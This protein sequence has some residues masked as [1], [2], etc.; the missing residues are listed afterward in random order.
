V[1][2]PYSP[3]RIAEVV[4]TAVILGIEATARDTGIDPRTIRGW[5]NRAGKAPADAI[6]CADWHSLGELARSQV[7]SSLASGKVRPKYAAVIAAI[8]T[9]N[10]RDPE[11]DPEPAD[12]EAEEWT[13]RLEAALTGKYGPTADLDELV[14]YMARWTQHELR[15]DPEAWPW[16]DPEALVAALPV[17]WDAWQAQRDA[18]HDAIAAES[19]ARRARSREAWPAFHAGRITEAQRD[20]WIRG[21]I[22]SPVA[23][24]QRAEV[25]ALLA[26]APAY[27]RESAA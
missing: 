20:A 22:E 13:R 21:E 10:A 11:P 19:D 23:E 15:E 24:Q 1:R 26:A 27:L 17:D 2:K 14:T 9:R 25:D 12:T 8:A 5:C 6:G 16:N 3:Q 7:V 18:E 4:A